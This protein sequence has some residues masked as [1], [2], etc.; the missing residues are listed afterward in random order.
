MNNA[1]VKPD[2]EKMSRRAWLRERVNMAYPDGRAV[3]P[4]RYRVLKFCTQGEWDRALAVRDEL[5]GYSG[6]AGLQELSVAAVEFLEG[7]T[8]EA[9]YHA[10]ALTQGDRLGVC[11]YFFGTREVVL[12]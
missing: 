9:G 6:N 10:G 4:R 3:T 8:S 5:L 12:V 1:N 11:D 7:Y 2:Y